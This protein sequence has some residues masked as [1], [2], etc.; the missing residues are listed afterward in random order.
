MGDEVQIVVEFQRGVVGAGLEDRIS[1]VVEQSVRVVEV[2]GGAAEVGVECILVV[3]GRSAVVDRRFVVE[4][5]VV[6]RSEVFRQARRS[7]KTYPGVDAHRQGLYAAVLG[8]DQHHAVRS[9]QAVEGGRRGVFEDRNRFDV[10]RGDAVGV[11]AHVTVHQNGG[12]PGVGRDAP[13]SP[14]I[15][16]IG[17]D[18]QLSVV[19]DAQKSGHPPVEQVGPV[20]SGQIFQLPAPDGRD[21]GRGQILVGRMVGR[22]HDGVRFYRERVGHGGSRFLRSIHRRQTRQKQTDACQIFESRYSHK[23]SFWVNIWVFVG[24]GCGLFHTERTVHK[25]RQFDR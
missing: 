19:L 18:A 12:L 5:C 10:G 9:P 13:E 16:R 15:H 3:F 11:L 17:F 21:G 7:L 22:H 8:R 24:S 1:A 6:V 20:Y 2:L 4:T 14:D 25:I 23:K